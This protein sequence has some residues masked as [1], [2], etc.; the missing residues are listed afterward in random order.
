MY[1]VGSDVKNIYKQ[2]TKLWA[3]SKF[4]TFVIGAFITIA[5]GVIFAVCLTGF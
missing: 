5:N 4:Q 2:E 3:P 1:R